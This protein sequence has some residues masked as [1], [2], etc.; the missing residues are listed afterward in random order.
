MVGA[1]DEHRKSHGRAWE[2]KRGNVEKET[3]NGKVLLKFG[4]MACIVQCA[5]YMNI[6]YKIGSLRIFCRY[7]ISIIGKKFP[8]VL[9]KSMDFRLINYFGNFLPIAACCSSPF[10]GRL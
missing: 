8:S 5:G 6:K 2:G 10:Y 9:L 1:M 7:N 3:E 4:D